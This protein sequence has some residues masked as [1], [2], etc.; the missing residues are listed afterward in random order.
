MTFYRQTGDVHAEA[1][2][3]FDA[4]VVPATGRPDVRPRKRY[5]PAVP[6][7]RLLCAPQHHDHDWAE[8]VSALPGGKLERQIGKWHANLFTQT[9]NA[10]KNASL[11]LF[12]FFLMSIIL[13]CPCDHWSVMEKKLDDK[14]R[15]TVHNILVCVTTI[16]PNKREKIYVN[17]VKL[18]LSIIFQTEKMN[19]NRELALTKIVMK[20]IVS[21]IRLKSD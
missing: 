8:R 3:V 13:L 12:Y 16:K 17:T 15:F 6:V 7:F 2:T 5:R 21:K 14:L 1:A 9:T 20:N 18:F 4:A 10:G 19:F 11:I